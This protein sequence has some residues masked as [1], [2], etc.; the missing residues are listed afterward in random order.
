MVISGG[1]GGGINGY[2][3]IHC[4]VR[5]R[6]T[7]TGVTLVTLRGNRPFPSSCLPPLQGESKFEVFVMKIRFHSYVKYN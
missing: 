4:K 7:Y 3:K 2:S 1:G 6:D 5:V